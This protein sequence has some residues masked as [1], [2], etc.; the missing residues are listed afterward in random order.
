MIILFILGGHR[1]AQAKRRAGSDLLVLAIHQDFAGDDEVVAD[2]QEHS[3]FERGLEP[4]IEV[5]GDAVVGEFGGWFH[6]F[7]LFARLD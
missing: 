6:G 7:G 4:R 2:E 1:L 5:N 3:L